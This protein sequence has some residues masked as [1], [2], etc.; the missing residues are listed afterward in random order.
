MRNKILLSA[1]ISFVLVLLCFVFYASAQTDTIK[2][3]L[4]SSN[5]QS[6]APWNN[7]TDS[8][9]GSISDCLN[10]EGENTGITVKVTDA[11]SGINEKGLLANDSLNL[12]GNAAKDSFFGHPLE[13][14][15]AAGPVEPSGGVKFSN[16]DPSKTYS[17]TLFGCRES[18]YDDRVAKYSVKGANEGTT[19]LNGSSNVDYFARVNNISPKSDGTITLTASADA[20][21]TNSLKFYYLNAILMT[22][23]RINTGAFLLDGVSSGISIYPNPAREFV[24][25]TLQ[26]KAFGVANF[27]IY[28]LTGKKVFNMQHSVCEG[29]NQIR[30]SIA[31]L[32]QG[33]YILKATERENSYS[34]KF[35]VSKN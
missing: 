13:G 3:D 24:Q 22:Y 16:L 25:L 4:G 2:I 17:F 21:N 6:P 33:I 18:D 28:N 12:A 11:F 31:N 5:Y 30:I 20:F 8:E 7:L 27:E 23:E 32:S 26:A 10:S 19:S 29:N 1:R 34:N 9:K 15:S 35:I 14:S